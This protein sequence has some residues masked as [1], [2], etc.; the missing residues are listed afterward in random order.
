MYEN[1]VSDL[2]FPDPANM[3]VFWGA[4][5]LPLPINP[6]PPI[7]GLLKSLEK[8]NIVLSQCECPDGDGV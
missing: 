3:L 4:P 8:Q 7:L 2:I 6:H 1:C 5:H